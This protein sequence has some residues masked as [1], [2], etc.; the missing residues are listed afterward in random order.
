V[1]VQTETRT[2]THK[3]QFNFIII[4][5]QGDTGRCWEQLSYV[6]VTITRIVKDTLLLLLLLLL[7]PPP[8]PLS[9][10]NSASNTKF[11]PKVSVLMFLCTNW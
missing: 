10:L 6:S 4:K 3:T 5:I 7:L 11:V 2:G 1:I 9:L 8:P